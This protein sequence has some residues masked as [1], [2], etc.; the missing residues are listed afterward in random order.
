MCWTVFLWHSS[1]VCRH[2]TISS[3]A[4]RGLLFESRIP[5][6]RNL[7]GFGCCR[8]LGQRTNPHERQSERTKHPQRR[9]P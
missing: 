5:V 7:D 4:R 3:R 9:Y 2:K 6:A 1:C 8:A